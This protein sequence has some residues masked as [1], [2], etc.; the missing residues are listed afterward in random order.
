MRYEKGLLAT[1][2]SVFLAA[3][4]L[5]LLAILGNTPLAS[6]LPMESRGKTVLMTTWWPGL[7]KVT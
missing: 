2:E 4:Q 7:G 5:V 6:S 3:Q 1:G